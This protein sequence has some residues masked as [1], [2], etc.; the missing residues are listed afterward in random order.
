MKKIARSALLLFAVLFN[1]WGIAWSQVTPNVQVLVA[2]KTLQDGTYLYQY[3]VTNRSNLSIVGFSIGSDYYHGISELNAPPL[4]WSFDDTTPPVSISSPN[5]WNAS[6]VTTEESPFFEIEWRNDGTADIAPGQSAVGFSVILP[7]A[8]NSYLN[9]HWTV[10]YAD[11]TIASSSLIVD[12]SPRITAKVASAEKQSNGQWKVSVE[13]SNSGTISAPQVT[14][15]QIN[16]RALAG[17]GQISIAS[18][19]LPVGLGELAAGAKKN[20][21]LILSIPNTVKKLS[22]TENGSLTISNVKYTFSSAQV[23]YPKNN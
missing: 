18:P 7:A 16:F 4:N 2:Q 15:T 9:S 23:V 19:S 5:A 22:I 1:F 14:I 21:D 6:V 11:S 8:N 12:G 13:V 17:S 3:R 10:L 20:I